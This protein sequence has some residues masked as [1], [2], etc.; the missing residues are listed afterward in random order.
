M[1]RVGDSRELYRR[2]QLI[3]LVLD[4]ASCEGT[5]EYNV[6]VWQGI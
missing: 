3:I 1:L 4:T 2:E 5:G 6:E